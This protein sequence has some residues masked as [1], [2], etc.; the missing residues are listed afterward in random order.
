[1][2][3]AHFHAKSNVYGCV[4]VISLSAYQVYDMCCAAKRLNEYVSFIIIAVE[5]NG[6]GVQLINS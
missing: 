2:K 5:I 1:M 3:L 6:L 4:Y